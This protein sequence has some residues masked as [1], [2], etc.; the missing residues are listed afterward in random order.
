MKE[1][2]LK[3]VS[4]NLLFLKNKKDVSNQEIADGVGVAKSTVSEWINGK[5]MPR[6][7]VIYRLQNY[8]DVDLVEITTTLSD[9]MEN[10]LDI[11]LQK[12]EKYRGVALSERDK[13]IIRNWLDSIFKE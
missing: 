5:K 1:N 12:A 13:K 4:E 2:L 11:M 7:E 10:D 8:F 3:I 6:W 9:R